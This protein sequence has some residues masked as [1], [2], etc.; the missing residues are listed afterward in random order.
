MLIN[1]NKL[2]PFLFSFLFLSSTY[3]QADAT[4]A[5]DHPWYIGGIGGY[6]STTW[7]ALVPSA[8]NQNLALSLSIPEGAEEG[9]AT[10]GVMAGY[11]F[12]PHFAVEANYM[13]FPSSTVYFNTMSIFS[14]THDQD[15]SFKTKT[16]AIS[17]MGKIFL[18][19]PKTNVRI[20]SSAGPTALYRKD[21]L[22]NDWRL[23]PTFGLGVNYNFNEH[24]MGEL[25]GTY[26]TGFGES[27][28]SPADSYFPFLYS[29]TAR[30]A[31]RF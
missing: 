5:Y 25:A 15:I 29:V 11:E 16:D 2:N 23:T 14:F 8:K 13:H 19:I 9:G 21:L 20:Y 22:V 6:G 3:C 24:I 4:K 31:Y 30:V 10:W 27:Q 12:T 18:T 28:L 7:H 26:T 1:N 17:L